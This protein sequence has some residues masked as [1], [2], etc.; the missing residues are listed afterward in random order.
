MAT[1][2]L[3]LPPEKASGFYLLIFMGI[4]VALAMGMLSFIGI[5][6]SH[7]LTVTELV[8]RLTRTLANQDKAVAPPK[9]PR[10]GS[11]KPGSVK[12]SRSQVRSRGLSLIESGAVTTTSGVG[13]YPLADVKSGRMYPQDIAYLEVLAH[14]GFKVR[15]SCVNSGHSDFVSRTLKPSLHKAWQAFDIDRINGRPICLKIVGRRTLRSDT[16]RCAKPSGETLRLNKWLY[17]Q[18]NAALPFE[19]GGPLKL[20]RRGK[21]SGPRGSR[22]GPFFT[23][24]GHQGHFHFGFKPANPNYPRGSWWVGN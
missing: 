22:G 1:P 3:E 20:G 17:S 11:I 9:V 6:P 16:R 23:N 18:S 14:A 24:G 12:M 4:V 10:P 2:P 15:V 7:G 21:Y 5:I 8:E 13:C 19:V